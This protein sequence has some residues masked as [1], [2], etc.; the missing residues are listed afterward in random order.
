MRHPTHDVTV[1]L[2]KR[3]YT[4]HAHDGRATSVVSLAST[5]VA[6]AGS[7]RGYRNGVIRS[8]SFGSEAITALPGKA[9]EF[10]VVDHRQGKRT[11][12]WSLDGTLT[13]KP[14][15]GGSILLV[16]KHGSMVSSILPVEILT[17]SGTNVT[18]AGLHWSLARHGGS[19][20]LELRLDDAHLPLAVHDRPV[21]HVD[22]CVERQRPHRHVPHLQR[23]ADVGEPAPARRLQRREHDHVVVS[24]DE[25]HLQRRRDDARAEQPGRGDEPVAELRLHG[26]LLH[27]EPADG[28]AQRRDQ[29]RR[30]V[31]GRHRR[32]RRGLLERLAER[33]GGLDRDDEPGAWSHLDRIHDEVAEPDA[34]RHDRSGRHDR[35]HGHLERRSR[36]DVSRSRRLVRPRA[37]ATRSA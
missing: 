25:R 8:T 35:H 5:A 2:D 15:P 16:D 19:H 30:A 22:R 1:A 17:Q 14:G 10:L 21:G 24:G 28:R 32:R 26:A 34:R 13:P 6:A 37:A 11:W 18:P 27:D 9:E 29:L 23:L 31:R 20:I 33:G 12:R 4:V 3:G 36:S 7:W